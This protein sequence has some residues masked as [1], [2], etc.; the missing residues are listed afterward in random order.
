MRSVTKIVDRPLNAF[1]ALALVQLDR[2]ARLELV[3]AD[4]DTASG[5]RLGAELVLAGEYPSRRHMDGFRHGIA[6]VIERA[7][8]AIQWRGRILLD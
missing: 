3:V 5:P 8:M 4:L 1:D 2:L 6:D 7:A